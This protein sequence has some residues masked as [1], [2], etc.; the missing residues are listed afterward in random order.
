[1]PSK[2]MQSIHWAMYRPTNGAFALF[3]AIHTCDIVSKQFLFSIR[4]AVV[5]S[6]LTLEVL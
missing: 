3:L 2:Q 4:L 1:M 6:Y 5:C